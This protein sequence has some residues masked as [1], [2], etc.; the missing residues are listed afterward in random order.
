MAEHATVEYETASGNDYAQHE[1]T[2]RSFLQLVKWG[3]GSV[4]LVL[5][6]MAIFL[7]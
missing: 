4:V 3:A 7:V 2:Y 1:A 6:L 5:V